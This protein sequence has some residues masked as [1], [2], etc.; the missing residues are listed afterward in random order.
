[1]EYTAN[2]TGT[3]N[4]GSVREKVWNYFDNFKGDKVIRKILML[5]IIISLITIFGSASSLAAAEENVTRLDIFFSQFKLA[6]AGMLIIIVIYNFRNLFLI[7]AGAS[8]G[9][10]VSLVLLVC[11]I[12][13]IG[14]ITVNGATRALKIA[15]QQIYIFEIIKV[16]MVMY[17]AWAIDAYKA[18]SFR[19]PK[20]L[21]VLSPKLA[22]LEKP[23]AKRLFYI[24]LPI[25]IVA[26]GMFKGGIS[27]TLFTGL[28]M[29]VIIFLGGMPKREIFGALFAGICMIGLFV[30]AMAIVYLLCR[31]MRFD[32]ADTI[33]AVFCGS[34]KSL[35][36]GSVMSRVLFGASPMTG[37]ILL[38]TML[39][40]AFQLIIVSITAKKIGQEQSE[41]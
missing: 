24:Y 25:L 27:S 38:P 5:L 29:F 32:R 26:G 19:L 39:Y 21:A 36:H 34:K 22:F 7:K 10:I 37:V 12:S 16:A 17:L 9:F 11:L 40:H 2:D 6:C 23:W 14:A 28:I 4:S 18:D 35:V 8:L 1:M 3:P 31:L 20:A 15:G 33:T 13:G 41:K 30:L